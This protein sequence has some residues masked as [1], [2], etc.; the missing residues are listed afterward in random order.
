MAWGPTRE[1]LSAACI[2]PRAG[3]LPK[4]GQPDADICAA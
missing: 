4:A 1:V 2:S 3:T